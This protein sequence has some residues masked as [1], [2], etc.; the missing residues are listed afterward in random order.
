VGQQRTITRSK[1][2]RAAELI[3]HAHPAGLSRGALALALQ[4]NPSTWRTGG[5]EEELL[6]A[7]PDI[8]RDRGHLFNDGDRTAILLSLRAAEASGDA[9]WARE[10]RA[11]WDSL[12]TAPRGQTTLDVEEESRPSQGAVTSGSEPGP[13]VSGS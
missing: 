3:R 6:A 4:V 9:E 13:S 7:H 10:L 1:I 11:R 8:C 5:Y 2:D 12:R